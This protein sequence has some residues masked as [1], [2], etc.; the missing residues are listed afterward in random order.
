MAGADSFEVEVVY[1][2]PEKQRVFTVR[3]EAG[4]TAEQA[5]RQCG[6]LSEYPQIDLADAKLGVFGRRIAT[7][8]IVHPGDRIEIYR[9]LLVDPKAIR[10]LRAQARRGGRPS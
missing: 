3:I 8:T 4:T 1:A 10:R 2:L 9:P 6:V 5:V 7:S